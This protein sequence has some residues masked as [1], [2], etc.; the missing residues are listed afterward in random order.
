M[1]ECP[2]IEKKLILKFTNRFELVKN[3]YKRLAVAPRVRV[4][5]EAAF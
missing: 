2:D 5:F 4:K 1:A 3:L